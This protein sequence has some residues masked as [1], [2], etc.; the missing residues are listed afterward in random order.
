MKDKILELI[1]TYAGKVSNWA[2]K[3]R[4]NRGRRKK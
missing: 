4:W 1:C 3:K 2:W